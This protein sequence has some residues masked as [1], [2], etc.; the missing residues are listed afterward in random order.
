MTDNIP[1]FVCLV[2]LINLLDHLD[3]HDRGL[4]PFD[5]IDR[6]GITMPTDKDAYCWDYPEQ[7]LAIIVP[8]TVF[9]Q[10]DRSIEIQ[11]QRR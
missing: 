3:D 11:T 2:K 4:S 9:E 10:Q 1:Y 5:Y 6:M 8:R 7:C